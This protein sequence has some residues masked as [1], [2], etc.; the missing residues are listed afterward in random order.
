[1]RKNVIVYGVGARKAGVGKKS[2]KKY[3]FTEISIGYEADGV[4]GVKCETIA[5]DAQIIGDRTIAPGD[6]LDLVMHQ[7]NFKT[8]VDAIL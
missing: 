4:T 6:S 8:Y 2:G 5:V 1:M 3:D 7:A